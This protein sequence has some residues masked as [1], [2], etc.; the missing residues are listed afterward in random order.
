MIGIYYKVLAHEIIEAEISN[1]L[2]VRDLGKSVVQFKS[3][4][5]RGQLVYTIVGGRLRSKGMEGRGT[6]VGQI[7]SQA[8]GAQI[9][10]SSAL[11]C[12][13]PS[14][15]GEGHLLYSIHRFKC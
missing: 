15:F 6:L 11:L 4:K 14:H 13:S 12:S 2:Q 7:S 5:F 3:I 9:Y 1:D 10:S 8:D